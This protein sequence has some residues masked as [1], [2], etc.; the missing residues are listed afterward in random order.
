MADISG[1]IQVNCLMEVNVPSKWGQQHTIK[2]VYHELMV[3]KLFFK[4]VFRF[5]VDSVTV[6][7]NAASRLYE[8]Q[9]GISDSFNKFSKKKIFSSKI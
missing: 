2:R 8:S 6:I 1:E 3:C 4:T 7:C 5:E 9:V